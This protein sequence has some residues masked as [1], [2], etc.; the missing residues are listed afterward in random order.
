MTQ[1]AWSRHWVRGLPPGQWNR[2]WQ[3]LVA[4]VSALD[5]WSLLRTEQ[6]TYADAPEPAE[7]SYF[8]TRASTIV[9]EHPNPTGVGRSV[10]W[11][12]PGGMAT[13]IDDLT[14]LVSLLTS[15]NVHTAYRERTLGDGQLNTMTHPT[16]ADSPTPELVPESDWPLTVATSFAQLAVPGWQSTSGFDRASWWYRHAM[17]MRPPSAPHVLAIA[18]F[19]V[20]LEV[21]AKG[22]GQTG[23]KK[24]GV[25]RLA[26]SLG[27]TGTAWGFLGSAVDDWYEARNYAFHEGISPS[28]TSSQLAGRERQA[29]AFA[30]LAL[31]R[32][33]SNQL[34]IGSN[35]AALIEAM[36]P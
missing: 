28:W 1:R 2:I 3:G 10:L 34:T 9:L 12:D 25:K 29:A 6:V 27:F 15:I 32:H 14:F 23:L 18:Q 30:G 26:D 22:S 24:P 8:R 17:T 36:R 11:S 13:T 20:V 4:Q 16:S 21:L 19:W 7:A 5:G 31:A 33:V 35:A